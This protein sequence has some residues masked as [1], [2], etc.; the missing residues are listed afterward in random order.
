MCFL[1]LYSI[2][3][4]SVYEPFR[5]FVVPRKVTRGVLVKVQRCARDRAIAPE[6]VLGS[7]RSGCSFGV[8]ECLTYL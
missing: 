8:R 5:S 3:Y 2:C 1:D 4:V 6:T 7:P